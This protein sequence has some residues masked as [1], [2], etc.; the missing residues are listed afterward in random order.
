[1]GKETERCTSLSTMVSDLVTSRNRCVRY[2]K[3]DIFQGG[4]QVEFRRLL[5]GYV[6]G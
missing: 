2:V 3:D 5:I 1:M 4:L 6:S